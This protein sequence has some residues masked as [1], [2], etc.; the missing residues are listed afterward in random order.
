MLPEQSTPLLQDRIKCAVKARPLLL[1]AAKQRDAFAIL[2]DPGENI[3]VIGF[4]LIDG[5]RDRH[6][7]TTNQEHRAAGHD[8]VDHCRDHQK[9]RN[10]DCERSDAKR[11]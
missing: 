7:P 8:G 10:G 4:C 11:Q 1:L 5:F 2:A 3:A 6:E 9:A